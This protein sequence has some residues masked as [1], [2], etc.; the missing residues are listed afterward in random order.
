MNTPL[1]PPSTWEKTVPLSIV[2]ADAV[3]V[4]LSLPRH[5]EVFLD[6]ESFDKH[7]TRQQIRHRVGSSLPFGGFITSHSN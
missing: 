2:V 5:L 6:M 1:F 4:H 7:S 3:A